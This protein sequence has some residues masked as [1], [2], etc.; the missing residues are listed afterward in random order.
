MK[1]IVDTIKFIS[2]I[3]GRKIVEKFK[4]G[5]EAGSNAASELL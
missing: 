5:F 2:F 1:T 3:V 4:E